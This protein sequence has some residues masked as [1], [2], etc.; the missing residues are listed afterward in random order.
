MSFSIRRSP[1]TT[2]TVVLS[3]V[4][5]TLGISVSGLLSVRKA[6]AQTKIPYS[7]TQAGMNE[8]AGKILAKA[9]AEMNQAYKK[10]MADLDTKSQAKLRESQ[11]QWIKFRDAEAEFLSLKFLGGSAYPMVYA[12]NKTSL[13]QQ[14]TKELKDTYKNFHSAG[15]M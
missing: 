15:M 14:R 3:T 5:L 8:T 13:T 6:E 10:L 7:Q 9:D 4:L 2:S 1:L 11:R 12:G